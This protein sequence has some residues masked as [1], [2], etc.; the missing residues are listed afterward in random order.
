[1]WLKVLLIVFN[2]FSQNLSQISNFAIWTKNE[3]YFGYPENKFVRLITTT[4]LKTLL[5][6]P[7]AGTLTIHNIDYTGHPLE[8]A[9]LLN[10]CITCANTKKIYIVIYNEDSMQWVPQD[11]L[12]QV[13]IDNFLV[14][15]FL[16]SGMPELILWDKHQI[17]YSYQNFTTTGVLQTSAGHGNLSAISNDSIIHDIYVGEFS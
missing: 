3:I 16:L 9:V 1:M 11:F 6:L 15:R 7:P 17:H 2:I 4:E 13:P 8:L 14:P 12:L 10:Y 5:N